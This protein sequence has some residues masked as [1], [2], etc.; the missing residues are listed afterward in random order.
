MNPE[1]MAMRLMLFPN[2][3]VLDGD[4]R[5]LSEVS[6]RD[7]RLMKQGSPYAANTT[8]SDKTLLFDAIIN[9]SNDSR[10]ADKLW[11]TIKR[12]CPCWGFLPLR[13][14]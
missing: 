9:I 6:T 3:A 14:C 13:T 1:D 5:L 2:V 10:S 8:K 4:L 11:V 7:L 12:Y